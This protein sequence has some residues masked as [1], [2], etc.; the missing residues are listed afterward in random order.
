MRGWAEAQSRENDSRVT[1][2]AGRGTMMVRER[3]WSRREEEMKVGRE[4]EPSWMPN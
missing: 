4:G 3:N 2:V 1:V